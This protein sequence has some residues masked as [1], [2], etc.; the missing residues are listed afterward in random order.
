MSVG[1]EVFEVKD[2]GELRSVPLD[3]TSLMGALIVVDHDRKNIWFWRE[4]EDIPKRLQIVGSRIMKSLKLK[5]GM[6]YSTNEVVGSKEP[7]TFLMLFEEQLRETKKPGK[8]LA[9]R[10]AEFTRTKPITVK[11]EEEP[12]YTRIEMKTAEVQP[13]QVHAMRESLTI[14]ISINININL[15]DYES[16]DAKKLEDLIVKIRDVLEKL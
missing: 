15:I 16:F 13:A 9:E 12:P 6:N 4:S 14:P 3:P 5:F 2:N 10:K 8:R 7:G 11:V 1:V